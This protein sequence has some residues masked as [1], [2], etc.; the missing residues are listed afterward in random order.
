MSIAED[1]KPFDVS[2]LGELEKTLPESIQ[3]LLNNGSGDSSTSI[4]RRPLDPVSGADPE[5]GTLDNSALEEPAGPEDE[6]KARPTVEEVLKERAATHG[7]FADNA[8]ISQSL[9]RI[10]HGEVGWDRMSDVQR[11]ACT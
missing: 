5:T 2:T 7:D 10:A 8:R 11:E 6:E 3:A 9:K 4:L 1:R